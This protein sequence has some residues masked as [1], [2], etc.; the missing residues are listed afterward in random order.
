MPLSTEHHISLCP[1]KPLDPAKP[2][3]RRPRY[4]VGEFTAE[5]T[6]QGRRIRAI[7]IIIIIA[8]TMLVV[9]SS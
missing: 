5:P 2:I 9:L 8:M 6:Y 1:G 7:I 4:V 3:V